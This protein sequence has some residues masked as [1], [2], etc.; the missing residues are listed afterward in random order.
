[1]RVM[2]VIRLRARL[3]THLSADEVLPPLL[4]FLATFGLYLLSMPKTVG[5][6]DDGFFILAAYYN[7]VAHPPGYPLFTMVGHLFTLFPWGSIAARVHAASAFF[8]ALSC[9]LL[10]LIALRLFHSGWIAATCSGLLAGSATF[11]SQA[12][13]AEVYTLNVFF[14]LLLFYLILH[15]VSD[16]L[17]ERQGRE[18]KRKDGSYGLLAAITFV[19]GLSLSNHWPLII[20]STPALLV[21]LAL[22]WREV[23]GALWWVMPLVLFGLTP[24]LWMFWNAGADTPIT[25]FGPLERWQDLLSYVSREVYA[26]VDQRDTAGWD[27]KWAYIALSFKLL[28]DQFAWPTWLLGAIGIMT[29]FRRLRDPVAQAL[30]LGIVG[31]CVVLPLLLGFEDEPLW[32]MVYRVYPLVAFVLAT[33]FVGSALAWINERWRM[34]KGWHV[35][36]P[37][38]AMLVVAATAAENFGSNFRHGDHWAE[39]YARTL[40]ESLPREAILFVSEDSEAGPI[41]Y[42]HHVQG[43]RPD[44]EIYHID[45]SIFVNRLFI[46]MRTGAVDRNRIIADFVASTQRPVFFT[47][48]PKLGVGREDFW[49]YSGLAASFPATRVR[50]DTLEGSPLDAYIK[51]VLHAPDPID[52]WALLNH[53]LLIADLVPILAERVLTRPKGERRVDDEQNLVRAIA[54]FE[55][56]TALIQWM[57]GHSEDHWLGELGRHIDEAKHLFHQAYTKEQQ[58]LFHLFNMRYQ[59]RL[60]QHQAALSNCLRA[61]EIWPSI[62]NPAYEEYQKLVE[63]MSAGEP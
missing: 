22:R 52:P 48:D 29:Q 12:I 39:S 17:L 49:L 1:M 62:R 60:G 41:G 2:H 7:G 13:V 26:G 3:F 50:Y 55:G 10:Y 18:V 5:F 58:A 9:M 16:E 11:W 19:Y 8:G 47:E 14:F 57:L 38:L 32:Q 15:Y 34:I 27:D 28:V 23:M 46:P 56:R 21:L 25:F 40:L 31:N 63:T 44:V 24:Y 35:L 61:M 51:R 37:G 45:G 33:L 43:V 54:R 6:E 36:F 20:L 4:I 30:A 53:R 59:L 42:L